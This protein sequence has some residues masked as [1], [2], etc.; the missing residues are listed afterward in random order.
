MK[1]EKK[2]LAEFSEVFMTNSGFKLLAKAI[3]GKPLK[4][5]KCVAGSGF[6]SENQDVLELEDVIEPRRDMEIESMQIPDHIGTATIAAV[7]S[8]E[9]LSE[10]FLLREI[11]LYA[12]DPESGKE[13]LYGYCNAGDKP[14]PIPGQDSMNPVYYR[15][16]LTIFIEQAKN[17]T[18]IYADNP[19]HVSYIE[20]NNSIDK[21]LLYLREKIDELQRQINILSELN[22]NKSLSYYAKNQEIKN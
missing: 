17:V 15:F 2:V 22:I 8:N 11:G 9:N 4:F 1:G 14:D 18:A 19:L 21:V 3:T 6:L 5:T 13:I 7:M 12:E 10:G 16:Y 20:M